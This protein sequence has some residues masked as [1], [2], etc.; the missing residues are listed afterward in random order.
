MPD[1]NREVSRAKLYFAQDLQIEPETYSVLQSG[2]A[3]RLT[4]LEFDLLANLVMRSGRICSRES[5]LRAVSGNEYIVLDRTID[6]HIAS[7]RRKLGDC[8]KTPKYIQTVR[9]VGY[10]LMESPPLVRGEHVCGDAG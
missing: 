6:V 4:R 2:E 3:I 8:P 1:A 7:L 5:L 9:G 10:L